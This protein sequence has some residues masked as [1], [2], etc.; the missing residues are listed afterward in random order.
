[1]IVFQKLAVR[2]LDVFNNIFGKMELYGNV[3]YAIY[4]LLTFLKMAYGK[5]RILESK[6]HDPR[7]VPTYSMQFM[8]APL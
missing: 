2:N 1:M 7:Q 4:A 8:C 3:F 6:S 5:A